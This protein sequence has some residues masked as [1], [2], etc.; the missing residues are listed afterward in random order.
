MHVQVVL[1]W[2][3]GLSLST[4]SAGNSRPRVNIYE[5]KTKD[6]HFV[7]KGPKGCKAMTAQGNFVKVYV[8]QT[9]LSINLFPFIVPP[10]SELFE[11]MGFYPYA[12]K[13]LCIEFFS[14]FYPWMRDLTT[15]ETSI[16]LCYVTTILIS[17]RRLESE[18]NFP[19]VKR[20]Y[21]TFI[22][23]GL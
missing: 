21:I 1:S 2:L 11:G 18:F 3:D 8:L 17:T 23:K 6:T 20:I 9:L 14:S 12:I 4:L 19:S 5:I 22:K 13:S 10:V 16:Y 15:S 7:I